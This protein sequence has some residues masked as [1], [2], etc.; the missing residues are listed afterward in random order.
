MSRLN[1][2]TMILILLLL[3]TMLIVWLVNRQIAPYTVVKTPPEFGALW[4]KAAY[5][6]GVPSRSLRGV[7]L[8][9][10]NKPL[11]K[12]GHPLVNAAWVERDQV[13]IKVPSA[14]D[15]QVLH[16]MIHAQ[17]HDTT[18]VHPQDIVRRCPEV[19]DSWN[20]FMNQDTR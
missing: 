3:A 19:D 18:N 7:H 20:N 5:C 8:A 15:A 4:A 14:T 1:P 6:A 10:A 9:I 2:R 12:P 13:L 16:E 17:R 11:E